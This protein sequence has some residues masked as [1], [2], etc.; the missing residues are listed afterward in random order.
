MG[1][2]TDKETTL[3]CQRPAI[4]LEIITLQQINAIRI[5]SNSSNNNHIE[6]NLTPE[7]KPT[8]DLA[9]KTTT[10]IITITTTITAL[11]T[12]IITTKTTIGAIITKTFLLI[13]SSAIRIIIAQTI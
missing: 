8:I 12:T 1:Q 13:A 3:K 7:I 9:I 6:P 4:I 10:T 11:T 5:I 2:T